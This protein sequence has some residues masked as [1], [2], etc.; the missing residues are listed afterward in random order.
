[1]TLPAALPTEGIVAGAQDH[2]EGHV[3]E[4]TLI[5]AIRASLGDTIDGLPE[6]TVRAAIDAADTAIAQEVSDR[7]SAISIE[8]AARVAADAS[9]QAVVDVNEA[10]ATAAI[11]AVQADVDA[12][13]ATAAAAT[14]AEASAR[15]AADTAL[16]GRVDDNGAALAAIVAADAVRSAA[17]GATQLEAAGWFRESFITGEDFTNNNRLGLLTRTAAGGSWAAPLPHTDQLFSGVNGRWEGSPVDLDGHEAS[18]VFIHLAHDFDARPVTTA[19]TFTRAS[20]GH[21]DGVEYASGA[22]RLVQGPNLLSAG[23]ANFQSGMGT[24]GWLSWAGSGPPSLADAVKL[25]G[26]RSLGITMNG[27]STAAVRNDS[28]RVTAGKTYTF[29]TSAYTTVADR[30]CRVVLTYLDK[31]GSVLATNDGDFVTMTTGTWMTLPA[32]TAL[33]PAGAV[34]AR[35]GVY[36]RKLSTSTAPDNG[37]VL[38]IDKA[39]MREG[40]AT[41]WT[42]GGRT[43][44]LVEEGTTNRVTTAAPTG[45]NGTVTSGQADPDGGTAAYR[46]TDD[47]ATGTHFIEWNVSGTTSAQHLVYAVLKAGTIDQALIRYSPGDGQAQATFDLTDE[48]SVVSTA[49]KVADAGTIPV[50]GGWVLCW[51][52]TDGVTTASRVQVLTFSEGTSYTG[53]GTG[54]LYAYHPQVQTGPLYPVSW[55]DPADGAREDE[56][57]VLT[58]LPL[59]THGTIEVDFYVSEATLLQDSTKPGHVIV[60][61]DGAGTNQ[62][63][64][65]LRIK[66]GS[67]EML[68]ADDTTAIVSGGTPTVGWHRALVAWSPSGTALVIDGAPV[69]TTA[70]TLDLAGQQLTIAADATNVRMTNAPVAAVRVSSKDRSSDPTAEVL[71]CD[72]ATTWLMTVDPDNGLAVHDRTDLTGTIQARLD[73][74]ED[75]EA[76]QPGWNDLGHTG[77]QLQVRVDVTRDDGSL[78][79][80]QI[81]GAAGGVLAYAR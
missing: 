36:M 27:G 21:A 15:A 55:H 44:V 73:T 58:G 51:V 81:D 77:D 30:E 50:P 6:G 4:R 34:Q 9:V 40:T 60:I 56:R 43:A 24:S 32:E 46:F 29:F 72:G 38:Y 14:S 16:S 18:K 63:R 48:G 78:S 23:A 67:W 62:Q 64:L 12:N 5:N 2:P 3:A 74:D 45:N 70:R 28:V 7:A 71:T 79:T 54:T 49:S 22:P 11:A 20:I 52:L 59:G 76:V 66:T 75:Y 39:C 57:I 35:I 17:D 25:L 65:L 26:D 80:G 53:D 10:A 33:A 41:Q 37:D 47:T 19:P 13:E 68:A 61:D 42:P 1:M 31:D 8:A 69:A